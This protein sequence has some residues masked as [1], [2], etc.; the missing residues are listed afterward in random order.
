[1]CWAEQKSEVSIA[2]KIFNII[3]WPSANNLHNVGS[4]SNK[5][6]YHDLSCPSRDK[7]CANIFSAHRNKNK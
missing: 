5:I 7:A 3:L 1:M 4:S 2:A 6:D